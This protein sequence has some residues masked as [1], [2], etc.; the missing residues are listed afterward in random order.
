MILIKTH[1]PPQDENSKSRI[2]ILGSFFAFFILGLLG[3]LFYLQVL[4]PGPWRSLAPIQYES[5]T[6]LQARRGLIY[7]RQHNVLAM[8]LPSYSLA[9]DPSLIKDLNKTARAVAD[10]IGDDSERIY[11][12]F[13]KHEK[14]RYVHISN[15]IT[16]DQKSELEAMDER[17]IIV[18]RGL[19]RMYPFDSLARPLIGRTDARHEGIAGIEQNFNTILAGQDGWAILQRDALNNNFSTVDYP[20]EPAL[21]GKHLVLTIDYVYQAVIE[22]ELRR[23]VE[24]YQARWGSAVLMHPVTGEILAMA[25]IIGPRL[26]RENDDFQSGIRNRSIQDSYEPGSVFK[27]V[28]L[29]AVLNENVY[30]PQS[31]IY[32]E[33]GDYSIGGQKIR[34]DNRSFQWLTVSR[35]LQ[36]SSNIGLSKMVKKL[37]KDKFYRYI[38]D[39][40]FGNRTG[41]GLPDETSGALNPPYEWNDFMTATLSFGQG[42]SVS[43]LQ[44]ASMMSVIAN[45][46]ELMEPHVCMEILDEQGRPV[47]ASEPKTIRRVI[48]QKTASQITEILEGVVSEG[49]GMKASVQGL[50]IAGKTGT[51]QKSIPGTDGYMPGLVVASFSG[52]WPVNS[53]EFVLVVTLDEPIPATLSAQN[54][55]P[56]FANMARR[57]SGMSGAPSQP[58]PIEDRVSSEFAL[59]GYK[60]AARETAEPVNNPKISPYF[61]P[62]LTG[63]T[64]RQALRRLA[65]CSIE[66]R[67][68]GSGIVRE[69]NLAPGIRIKKNMVCELRCQ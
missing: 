31:L 62:D 5:R 55:A 61:V 46:G 15:D 52:F 2:I 63:L 19:T 7:D 38:Q 37:G 33:N 6:K 21:D 29:A 32:C 56:V 1:K 39:F 24:K 13:K 67:V 8:D 35:V 3:R 53:P 43:T 27:V 41:I 50:R 54:A 18:E 36:V 47:Q 34:D 25:S 64:L 9:A 12:I 30:N 58:E 45:G 68:Q 22:E 49:T 14:S 4:N 20:V 23:G 40:G 57:I 11:W 17:A 59:S 44:L 10:V 26:Q 51:A 48:S 69:Q 65:V 16:E 42:L 60:M 28:A 66:A